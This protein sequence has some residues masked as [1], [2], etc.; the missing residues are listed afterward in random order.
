MNKR[1]LVICT[2]LVFSIFANAQKKSDML[3][4]ISNLKTE[5]DSLKSLVTTA[6]KNEK[7]STARAESFESQVTELQDANTTL[8]KNLNTFAEISSKNSD[9]VNAAMASLQNKENQLKYIRDAISQNDSTAVIVLTNSKQTLG[10]NAKISVVNGEVVISESLP[11]LFGNDTGTTVS[12]SSESFLGQ[13][14]S[15]LN[16]NPNMMLTVEG[17]SMTGDLDLPAKQAA[18]IT[19]LLQKKFAVDPSRMGSLGRDGNLKEGILMRIH[20]KYDQ[21]YLMV[22]GNMKATK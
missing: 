1:I 10:E 21:F 16:A 9:N 22:R 5:R 11:V 4:E 7:V 13:I 14:A 17:L 2:F 12:G 6:Q 8:M 18:S 15:V 20:P 3:V 19:A